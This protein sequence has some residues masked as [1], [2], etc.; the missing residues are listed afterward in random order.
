MPILGS[1]PP[2]VLLDNPTY[3]AGRRFGPTQVTIGDVTWGL[4]DANA[5]NWFFDDLDG[6]DDTP[7]VVSQKTQKVSQHGAHLGPQ[8]YAARSLT[9]NGWIAARTMALRETALRQLHRSLPVNALSVVRVSDPPERYVQARV[10]GQIK[11]KRIGQHCF[12]I[13]IPLVAPDPR[14]YGLNPD[15]VEIG[16]PD[17]AGGVTLPTSL[18]L[19]LP[20]RISGGTGE[21][22]NAGDMPAP[23]TARITGPVDVPV[24]EAVDL[25]QRIAVNIALGS[26]ETLDVDARTQTVVLNGATSRSGLIVRGSTWFELPAESSTTIRFGATAFDPGTPALSFVPLSAWS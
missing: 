17:F 16:V 13:Q 5:T 3:P 12:A 8:T 14:K 22:V 15:A 9:L 6:W 18:P 20:V 24:I 2:A 26:G 11:A 21:A 4:S 10:D 23:W 19:A 7:E 1:P 25:G